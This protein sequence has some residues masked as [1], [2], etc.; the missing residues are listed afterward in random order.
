MTHLCHLHIYL[1]WISSFYPNVKQILREVLLCCTRFLHINVIFPNWPRLFF[2]FLQV[3]ENVCL[4]RPDKAY[5]LADL[6]FVYVTLLLLQNLLHH[7]YE[8]RLG[9]SHF[10][11]IFTQRGLTAS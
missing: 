6:L 8:R 10:S 1:F 9:V 11:F 5:T 4:Y 7:L 3:S 2:T